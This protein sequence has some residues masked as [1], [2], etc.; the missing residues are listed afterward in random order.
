MTGGSFRFSETIESVLASSCSRLLTENSVSENERV[1]RHNGLDEA[2]V[3]DRVHCMS[4]YL[5]LHHPHA[6]PVLDHTQHVDRLR[7]FERSLRETRE[8]A[9]KVASKRDHAYLLENRRTL[10]AG[11]VERGDRSP[12]KEE[13]VPVNIHH[14]LD[15]VTIKVFFPADNTARQVHA[16]HGRI[17]DQGGRG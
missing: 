4:V 15:G 13:S 12:R 2:Q 17:P 11:E 10:D 7:P 3:F 14:N 8:I 6:S 5:G 1:V 9:K 16:R